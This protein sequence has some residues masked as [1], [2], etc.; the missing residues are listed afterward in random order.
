LGQLKLAVRAMKE[1]N[2]YTAGAKEESVYA[3][4]AKIYLTPRV[5]GGQGEV[6]NRFTQRSAS[7]GRSDNRPPQIRIARAD[8]KEVLVKTLEYG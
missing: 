6:F 7:P 8:G 1:E 4:G 5:S 3:R 2:R